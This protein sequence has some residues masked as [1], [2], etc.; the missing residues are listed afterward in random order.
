MILF[1]FQYIQLLFY[2]EIFIFLLQ[3]LLI[4]IIQNF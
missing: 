1:F 4:S 3:F 2:L